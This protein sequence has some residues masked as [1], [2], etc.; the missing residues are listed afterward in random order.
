MKLV[1]G[2][3]VREAFRHV[4]TGVA[5]VTARVAGRV[6]GM[7]VNSLASVCLEPPTL[8][9]CL[10]GGARTTRAVQRSGRFG[11]S[12]L[13]HAQAA[14]AR[15]F[16]TP[17]APRPELPAE[18]QDEAPVIPEALVQAQCVVADWKDVGDHA[19]AFGLIAS[20][21]TQDGIPLGFLNG[22]VGGLELQPD[23]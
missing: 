9:V 18:G 11:V 6:C 13:T 1:D 3:D 15:A 10:K 23:E 2:G 22:R 16:A 4:P 20:I 5:I 21:A 17:G 7:T 19:I 8:L 12:V 14:V